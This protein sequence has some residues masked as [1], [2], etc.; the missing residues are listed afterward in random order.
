M[1]WYVFNLI[2]A[3]SFGR[4]C[5]GRS[6]IRKKL[7]SV[8]EIFFYHLPTTFAKGSQSHCSPPAVISMWTKDNFRALKWTFVW[9]LIRHKVIKKRNCSYTRLSILN[10]RIPRKYVDNLFN[11]HNC[12][13]CN[14]IWSLE[15]MCRTLYETWYEHR[16]WSAM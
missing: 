13:R 16:F 14:L 5:N 9:Q 2:E 11:S 3:W 4:Y 8:F 6:I 7:N 1:N 10:H 15:V 12:K